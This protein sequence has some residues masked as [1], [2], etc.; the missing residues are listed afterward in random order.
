FVLHGLSQTAFAVLVLL[1]VLPVPCG[2]RSIPSDPRLARVADRL[3]ELRRLAASARQDSLEH[4]D[5]G[6]QTINV[7]PWPEEEDVVRV[8]DH[9][10]ARRLAQRLA[11][12]APDAA[13]DGRRSAHPETF[14][15]VLR[16]GA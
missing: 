5:G 12:P 6:G 10:M 13:V 16:E 3:R 11:P 7:Y 9:A 14:P 8:E 4:L 15:A 1:A 2:V